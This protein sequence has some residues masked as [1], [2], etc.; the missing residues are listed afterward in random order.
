MPGILDPI[1]IGSLQLKNRVVMSPMCQYQASN[2][3]GVAENWH[4]IHYVSRAIGGTGLIL[5]EMT[6]VEPKGRITEECLGIYDEAQIEALQRIVEECHRH[7][8]KVGLQISHAGRKSTISGSDIV[9]PSAVSF[10]DKSPI[11]RELLQEEIKELVTK[12]GRSAE[13]A[14]KAGFDCIELHA[15]HGYLLHQFMSPLSNKR[16][17]AYGDRAKFPLEVIAEV[18]SKLPAGMPLI[19]RVSAVEYHEDGYTF[20][21][22]AEM[23][24]AFKSHG[25]DVFDVSTGGNVPLRPQAYP[26]FRL[27]YA[28]A[29][30]KK[31][32]VTV[33]SV[34]S[35]D[36]PK[37]AEAAVRNGQTDM[38]CI[39]K[40]LLRSPYWVKEA[41]IVLKQDHVLPGVYNLG[42]E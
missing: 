38:V 14:V 33:M 10:S 8:A 18:K 40:G 12:F 6:D 39:G 13:L 16:T 34:G 37:V 29:L 21:E 27:N 36:D 17:D 7:G 31:L 26:A 20:E 32:G 4:L 22:L 24:E 15:A 23:C 41:A 9:A 5:L 1:Q 30:K 11:P 2:Q 28:E 3:Q 35:L 42:Y 19:C 25:V